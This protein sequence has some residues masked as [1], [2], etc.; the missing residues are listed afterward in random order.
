MADFIGD[1][2]M[3]SDDG[4]LRDGVLIKV[5]ENEALDELIEGIK[6]MM[7]IVN[8]EDQVPLHPTA[9]IAQ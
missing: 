9:Y 7:G 5:I 1:F 2:I 4:E 8:D 6:E 3:S